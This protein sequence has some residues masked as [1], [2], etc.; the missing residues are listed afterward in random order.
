MTKGKVLFSAASRDPAMATAVHNLLGAAL[1]QLADGDLCKPPTHG[2]KQAAAARRTNEDAERERS[3]ASKSAAPAADGAG[4]ATAPAPEPEVVVM[5]NAKKSASTKRRV[6]A[7]TGQRASAN[8][9][10]KTAKNGRRGEARPA[11]GHAHS[12]LTQ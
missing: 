3:A 5:P 7:G 12:N 6:T 4:V 8:K 1:T 10:A 9:Q 2:R 11:R